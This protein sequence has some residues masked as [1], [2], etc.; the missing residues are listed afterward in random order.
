[1]T[2]SLDSRLCD[3]LTELE[4]Q[5]ARLL[6]WGVV[7]GGFAQTELEDRVRAFL[8]RRSAEETAGEFV[9]ELLKRRLLFR[10][11]V[12]SEPLYR[13]RMAET[14]RLVARLRQLFP[15]RSWRTAPTLVADYRFAL[16]PRVYPE[17]NLPADEFLTDVATEFELHQVQRAAMTELLTQADGSW[18]ELAEFQTRATRR[19]LRDLRKRTITRGMIVGAGTGTGKTLAFY[20]PALAYLASLVRSTSYWTKAV[21][22]YPR[23]ELL[24]DQLN[25]AFRQARKL[26]GLLSGAAGRKLILGTFFGPTPYGCDRRSI[27]QVWEERAVG[28]VCPFLRCP[29]ETCGGE[30]I[31]QMGDVDA[32]VERLHCGTCRQTVAEDE[33]VL[34]RQRLTRTPPDLLFT[35]TEMLNRRISDAASRHVFGVRA[36]QPPRIVLLD[37]VHTYTGIHGAQVAYVLRRWRQALGGAPLHV[38]GLSATLE[39]AGEFFAALVGLPASG[40]EVVLPREGD[41]RREGVEYQLALRGDPASGAALLS[42]TIQTLMLLRRVL[43]SAADPRSR[44]TYGTR[45][46]AFTDDL[47]VTNRLYHDLLHA[48]GYRPGRPRGGSLA[49]LR[50]QSEPEPAERMRAGQSWLMAEEIHAPV[51]LGE[52]LV[53]GR[54]SSQ[55]VGVDPDAD[56]IVATA[57]LEVGFD[58][59]SV[60]AV[61]QHKAP[62]DAA[63]FLQRKGRAGRDRRMR[64]WTV[65]VLSDYGRDRLAYQAYDQLFAPVLNA[66]SL[67]VGNRHVLRMQA[68]YALID[69]VATQ[70][71]PSVGWGSVWNDFAAPQTSQGAVNRQALVK[72]VLEELLE[73]VASRGE[74]LQAYLTGALQ[75]PR[76]EV[77][78]L[79]WEPPR[80][81]ITAVVPTIL[82]RLETNWRRVPVGGETNQEPYYRG[83][84]LPEFTPGNLFSDLNL[85]EVTVITPPEFRGGEPHVARMP[86]LQALRTFAPGRPTRRFGIYTGKA[87]HWIAPPGFGGNGRAA[88]GDKPALL[89]VADVSVEAE[90]L[91]EVQVEHRG[92]I[93]SL[94]C[95]RPWLIRPVVLPPGVLPTSNA[96]LIW[97]SQIGPV[98]EGLD[99]PVPDHGAWANIIPGAT[100]YTHN[101]RTHIRVR[102]FALGSEVSLRLRTCED[103][104]SLGLIES[105][106]TP[107]AAAL[108]FGLDVDGIVFQ[109]ALPAGLHETPGSG[110]DGETPGAPHC[111]LPSPDPPRSGA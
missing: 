96:S 91:G 51:G 26:D 30:L 59:P 109:V 46:F 49:S 13:T 108:G 25:D 65:V 2:D 8:N 12:G 18:I 21:A 23:N 3:F 43:D 19:M 78:A 45:V 110:Y 100:A 9:Q 24:K 55:D 66:R 29:D 53:I 15:G 81:L 63:A 82:R 98:A 107:R 38:C 99:L 70:L 17:R 79:F 60:G 62:M 88:T 56:V 95:Y 69:W 64:P 71:P 101:Q 1:M 48:E 6:S 35:T 57:S 68:A 67:P 31:W 37:E 40:V 104:F 16:R 54:T 7:D 72:A 77:L 42:T 103:R 89:P 22:I 47:D 102:R 14:I 92:T 39:N 106:Q 34:T 36:Q 105:E 5:E 20:L 97:G 74:S 11:S 84:P 10:P 44:G 33:I 41:M 83:V 27:G 32:G 93:C 94:P 85:P 4:E 28:F 73:G 80:A 86:V 61:V 50:A 90:Y 76:D 75:I 58:D 111:V 87:T 52:P